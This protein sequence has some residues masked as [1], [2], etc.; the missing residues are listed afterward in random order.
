MDET[1]TASL[2]SAPQLGFWLM[3]RSVHV[4]DGAAGTAK[5]LLR[6]QKTA[7]MRPKQGLAASRAFRAVSAKPTNACRLGKP[8]DPA[9]FLS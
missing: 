8:F 9:D 1:W 5:I 6:R 3:I 2:H 7:K 4:D